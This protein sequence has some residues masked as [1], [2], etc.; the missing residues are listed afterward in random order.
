MGNLTG[1]SSSEKRFLPMTLNEYFTLVGT[2]HH[3]HRYELEHPNASNN[4]INVTYNKMD[5]LH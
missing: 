4:S 1:S 2:F 5:S 3:I